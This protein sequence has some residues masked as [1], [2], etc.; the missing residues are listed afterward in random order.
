MAQT[1]LVR[2]TDLLHEETLGLS[3]LPC[4]EHLSPQQYR[5]RVA[6][7]IEEIEIAARLAR[8][9]RGVPVLGLEAVLRQNPLTRPNPAL[10]SIQ[11]DVQANREIK[12]GPAEG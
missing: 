10:S 2:L 7:L 4:W 5:E 1:N 6:A 3:R 12:P 9:E 8:L 11:I